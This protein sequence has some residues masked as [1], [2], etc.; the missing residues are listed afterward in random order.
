[1]GNSV[2][3]YG[4]LLGKLSVVNCQLS[5]TVV[6]DKERTVKLFCCLV[7]ILEILNFIKRYFLFLFTTAVVFAAVG[8]VL[9][10]K[11]PPS[12]EASQTLFVKRQASAE[13]KQF[14]TY[15]GYYSAQAAERFAD[16]VFGALKSK[17]VVRYAILRVAP[18]MAGRP[19]LSSEVKSIKVVRL[20]PQL[21]SFS[22][23]NKSRELSEKL[24]KDLS[25]SVSSIAEDLSKGGDEGISISFVSSEPL[26]AEHRWGP[27]LGGLIGLLM[28]TFLALLISAAHYFYKNIP[29]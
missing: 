22:Y 26:V 2:I 20:S 29:S 1:M 16:S 23:S 4:Q 3:F 11:I 21:I 14:Y 7:T 8:A 18:Q 5:I 12:F 9:A 13:S 25:V 10:I 19:E 17:E 24:I 28:G 27:F 15:D 6:V